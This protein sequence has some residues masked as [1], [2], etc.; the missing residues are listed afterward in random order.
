MTRNPTERGG[1]PAARAGSCLCGAVRFEVVGPFPALYQCHCSLCRKQGGSVSNTAMIVAAER[2]LWTG[3]EASIGRWQRPTGFRSHF[4]TTCGST[5]PNPL[6]DTGYVWVPAGLLDEDGGL[7]I[8]A[9]LWLSSKMDG[10]I[11][12]AD[13]L[14]HPTAPTLAELIA[15]LHAD[16]HAST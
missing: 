10:D 13:G 4:C 15:F 2:F 7:L 6:R 16:A 8:E 5:I 1:G 14:Q 3:G 11:P 12:R 9:Q